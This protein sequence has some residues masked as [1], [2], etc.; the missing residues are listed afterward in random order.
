MRIKSFAKI[1]LGLEVVR[2]RGDKYHEIRTLFQTIDF[3]D[4]L[5]FRRTPHNKIS[6]EGND[7]TISWG[8]DNLIYKAAS[9]L[10]QQ[11]NLT[12][13]IEIQVTK[14]IPAGK[15]LGGGSSNAAMTLYALN[16]IWELHLEKSDM[17]DLGRNIGADVPYFFEGG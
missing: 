7:D 1:N 3:H 10:K 5:H 13:G 4:I 11:F 6:L 16:K 12:D 17:M 2:K 15:G 9:L 14:N 8:E